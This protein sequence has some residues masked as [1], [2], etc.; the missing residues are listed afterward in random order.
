[1]TLDKKGALLLLLGYALNSLGPACVP[2]GLSAFAVA[3]LFY[4]VWWWKEHRSW[5]QVGVSALC[6]T[7]A[8]AGAI[9]NFGLI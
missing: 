7:L 5:T 8:L 2:Y 3:N 4:G 6:G 1:M 9:T